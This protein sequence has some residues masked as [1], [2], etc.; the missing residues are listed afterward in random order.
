MWTVVASP[1]GALSE[2]RQDP[3]RASTLIWK[4]SR[5]SWE[6]VAWGG[7]RLWGGI[8]VDVGVVRELGLF[9]QLASEYKGPGLQSPREKP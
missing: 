6:G 8:G 2:E 3:R 5:Y 9:V 4:G 1:S 7:C